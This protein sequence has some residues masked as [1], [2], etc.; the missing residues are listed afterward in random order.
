MSCHGYLRNQKPSRAMFASSGR[1]RRVVMDCGT[2]AATCVQTAG[3][4]NRRK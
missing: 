3:L 2:L 1:E 4:K